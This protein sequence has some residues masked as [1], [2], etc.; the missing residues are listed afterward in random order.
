MAMGCPHQGRSG[1]LNATITSRP[2]DSPRPS[3]GGY[4][5]RVE[6]F[7]LSGFL[8]AESGRVRLSLRTRSTHRPREDIVPPRQNS[9]ILSGMTCRQATWTTANGTVSSAEVSAVDPHAV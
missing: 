4:V 8:A 1:G 6:R 9:S 2:F 5:R 7:N 3:P